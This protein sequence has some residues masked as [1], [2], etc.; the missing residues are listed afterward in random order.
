MMEN[1]GVSVIKCTQLPVSFLTATLD[2]RTDE[3]KDEFEQNV[4]KVR[5]TDAYDLAG[6]EVAIDVLPLQMRW[7]KDDP[8]SRFVNENVTSTST[9][10]G[11]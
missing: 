5:A 2:R 1:G 8:S 10:T 3:D 7:S 6:S 4:K 11:S 9:L